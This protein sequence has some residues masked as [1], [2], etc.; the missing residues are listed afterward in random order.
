MEYFE[1]SL[2][3]KCLQRIWNAEVQRRK[4]G[5]EGNYWFC[6]KL[7]VQEFVKVLS[8]CFCISAPQRLCA[9]AFQI[10]VREKEWSI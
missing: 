5:E 9:S 2:W 1:S 6:Y 4:G 8:F 3:F 7:K 10:E